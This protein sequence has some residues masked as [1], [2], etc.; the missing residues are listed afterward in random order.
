MVLVVVE[1]SERFYV[2]LAAYVTYAITDDHHL[3]ILRVLQLN[4]RQ[5]ASPHSVEDSL[6]VVTE[7]DAQGTSL[8][9][10]V[11]GR[12]YR[13]GQKSKLLILSKHV[14]KREKIG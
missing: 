4:V 10:S 12:Y 7:T 6:R 8:S 2:D 3:D 9:D 1:D 13:V 5:M 14:N 11:V